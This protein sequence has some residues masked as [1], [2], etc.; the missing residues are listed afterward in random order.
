MSNPVAS[1]N[2]GSFNVQ[3]TV[4]LTNGTDGD[5]LDTVISTTGDLTMSTT[6]G[7]TFTE[8]GGSYISASDTY[9]YGANHVHTFYG[10]YQM[11]TLL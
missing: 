5:G 6:T 2:I 9:N 11:L 4:A 10:T 3:V 8:S 7:L 1:T